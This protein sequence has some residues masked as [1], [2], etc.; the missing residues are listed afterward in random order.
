MIKEKYLLSVSFHDQD[1]EGFSFE[2]L[3][4]IISEIRKDI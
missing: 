3:E 4:I 2:K 1:Y